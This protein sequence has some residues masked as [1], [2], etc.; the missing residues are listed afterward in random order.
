MI[1]GVVQH[2]ND[3]AVSARRHK[4]EEGRFQLRVG[5]V[6]GGDV[7]AQVMHRDQRLVCG[8]GQPLGEIDAHQHRTN[9]A[10]RK[11][12]G[13]SIHVVDGLACVQQSLFDGGTDELAVTAACDFGN[14][15]AVKCLFLHAGRD[16]VA[17]QLSAILDQCCGGLVAGGFDT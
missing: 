5:Q 1:V 2:L 12:D 16:D 13:D 6:E 17:Q 11:G 8:V 14:D 9:Q 15:T 4:A 3:V 10:G 7:A